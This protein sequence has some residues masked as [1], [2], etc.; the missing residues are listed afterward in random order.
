[1][2]G[3]PWSGERMAVH[4]CSLAAVVR[5]RRRRRHNRPLLR[6]PAHALLLR[7]CHRV[8][9]FEL[10]ITFGAVARKLAAQ[11]ALNEP[12]YGAVHRPPPKRRIG[13]VDGAVGG[14]RIAI[15]GT[16]RRLSRQRKATAVEEG[17]D[18]GRDV[19]EVLLPFLGAGEFVVCVELLLRHQSPAPEE[20]EDGGEAG[21]GE[22]EEKPREVAPRGLHERT[23]GD[24]P[25]P[26]PDNVVIIPTFAL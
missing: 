5:G 13:A 23:D 12:G 26:P 15:S 22:G 8:A 18:D 25:D 3:K 4:R 19:G 16:R 9:S 10:S 14:V 24:N 2:G 7:V 21:G 11:R 17:G 6:L 1:M 20:H